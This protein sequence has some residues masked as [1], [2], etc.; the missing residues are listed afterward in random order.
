MSI[1]IWAAFILLALLFLF[2]VYCGIAGKSFLLQP[3]QVSQQQVAAYDA[4][5][6]K[7]IIEAARRRHP[8]KSEIDLYRDEIYRIERDRWR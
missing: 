1:V 5:T 8:H 4:D 3:P 7:R 6:C 2:I